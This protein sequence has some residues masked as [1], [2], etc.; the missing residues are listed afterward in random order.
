[1]NEL[2]PQA[3]PGQIELLVRVL[4][5]TENIINHFDLSNAYDLLSGISSKQVRYVNALI[6]NKKYFDLNKFLEGRGFTK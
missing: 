6:I 3:T 2:N 1:M 4:E 5:R